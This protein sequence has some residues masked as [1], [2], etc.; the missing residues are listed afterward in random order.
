MYELARLIFLVIG[1]FLFAKEAIEY[2]KNDVF[3]CWFLI[4]FIGA[5]IRIRILRDGIKKEAEKE[6]TTAQKEKSEKKSDFQTR[7]EKRNAEIKKKQAEQKNKQVPEK[8]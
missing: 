3:S 4:F 7:V 5:I 1:C 2:F 8:N 6:R